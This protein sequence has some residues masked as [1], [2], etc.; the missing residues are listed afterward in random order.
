[1]AALWLLAAFLF[2]QIAAR[3]FSIRGVYPDAFLVAVIY[4]ALHSDSRRAG[5]YGLIAG[6]CEDLLDL[7][8][9]GS[10]TVSTTLVGL[11]AGMLSRNFFSDSLLL[12][13]SLAAIATL[14]REAI[15]W[16]M[17]SLE[18]YP[19]GLAGIHFHAALWQALLN[20]ALIAI[21]ILL[22][23]WRENYRTR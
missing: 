8:S 22:G 9:G 6:L 20:A 14:V 21:V 1:M 13:A 17:R 5:I 16:I 2:S 11:L 18:G 4:Y 3:W 23:R 12:A 15:F 19:A 10:W 7:G